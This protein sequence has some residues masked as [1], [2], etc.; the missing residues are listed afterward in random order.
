MIFRLQYVGGNPTLQFDEQIR[1]IEAE[2][3]LEAFHKARRIGHLE[4]DPVPHTPEKPVW[5]Q[6]VDITSLIKLEPHK[7]GAEIF[8]HIHE[9]DQAELY[10]KKIRINAKAILEGCLEETLEII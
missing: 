8:S 4:E 7:D 6:F 10:L 5:W 9:V 2:D 1:I 3:K